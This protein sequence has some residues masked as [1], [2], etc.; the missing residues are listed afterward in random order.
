MG[1]TKLVVTTNSIVD[2][3]DL[4]EGTVIDI[5]VLVIDIIAI[6]DMAVITI[7]EVAISISTMAEFTLTLR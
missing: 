2:I 5:A 6:T 4:T 1:T 3:A 7:T